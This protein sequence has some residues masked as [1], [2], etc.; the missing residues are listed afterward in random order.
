M[1]F[2]KRISRHLAGAGLVVALGLAAGSVI[3]QPARS[4]STCNMQ[5]VHTSGGQEA[6]EFSYNDWYCDWSSGGCKTR[7]CGSGALQCPPAGICQ[8]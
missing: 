4:Q 1:L 7:D 8:E 3:P 2:R 6:C 5:C